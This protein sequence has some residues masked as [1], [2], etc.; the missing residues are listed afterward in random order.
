MRVVSWNC[1]GAFRKKSEPLFSLE[2]DVYCI[3]ECENPEKHAHAFEE[4]LDGRNIIWKGTD[5]KGDKG[6]AVISRADIPISRL[7]WG[8]DELRDFLSVSIVGTDIAVV[9]VWAC[10]PYIEQFLAW[11]DICE[12]HVNEDTALL[13]DFNSNKVWD[14]KHGV[15][16]HTDAVGRLSR[17]GLESAYHLF[18]GEEQGEESQPT[19]FL[20]RH[21]DRPYHLD[22]A[23]ASP[24]LMTG[25]HIAYGDWLELSDHLPIVLELEVPGSTTVASPLRAQYT[26]DG[27]P[28]RPDM[29]DDITATVA[30][31]AAM[32]SISQKQAAETLLGGNVLREWQHDQQGDRRTGKD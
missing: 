7:D 13:G 14:V 31:Y 20:Y 5:P 8:G 32:K 4:L 30:S 18:S 22:Y 12:A 28:V 2:A 11:L 26:A 6:V 27:E 25:F 17:L 9:D 29:M 10:Q 15:S 1:A 21:A 16:C 24:S 19:F 3:Q 23:F